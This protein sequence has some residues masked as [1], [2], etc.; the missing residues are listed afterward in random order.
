MNEAVKTTCGR[1]GAQFGED[2]SQAK[3]TEQQVLDLRSRWQ[4]A[5]GRR[6]IKL[7]EQLS[8]AFHIS[9]RQVRNIV[10]RRSWPHI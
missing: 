4:N 1:I 6:G 5:V 7:I 8:A 2:N 10:F 9:K 3:L